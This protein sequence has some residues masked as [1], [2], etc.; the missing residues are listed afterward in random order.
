MPEQ[1]QRPRWCPTDLPDC[2]PARMINKVHLAET[3]LHLCSKLE[4]EQCASVSCFKRTYTEEKSVEW[5]QADG[6]L[7]T[8]RMKRS[9]SGREL[10]NGQEVSGQLAPHRCR[11]SPCREFIS[12]RELFIC[13]WVTGKPF[14][15]S[16]RGWCWPSIYLLRVKTQEYHWWSHCGAVR[17]GTWGDFPRVICL[18]H[19]EHLWAHERENN[20]L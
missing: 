19:E 1:H 6:L 2:R 17:L 3:R 11:C 9:F 4:R 18:M 20:T 14:I 10:V 7:N 16:P 15:S 5:L 13:Q 12:A 8:L